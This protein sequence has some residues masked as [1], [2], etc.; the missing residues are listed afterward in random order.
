MSQIVAKTGDYVSQVNSYLV[1]ASYLLNVIDM[2]PSD[3]NSWQN[4]T[5]CESASLQTYFALRAYLNEISSYYSKYRLSTE[6]VLLGRFFDNPPESIGKLTEFIEL[7]RFLSS[8]TR[9]WQ[10]LCNLPIWPDEMEYRKGM[11][12]NALVSQRLDTKNKN[13]AVELIDLK[14]YSEEEQLVDPE[15]LRLMITE[16][17]ELI[18][19]QRSNQMEF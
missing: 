2:L 7:K 17:T 16:L 19:H 10:R 8:S 5:F 9:P 15:S 11:P 6:Q 4:R 18:D 12:S 1:S 3:P 14:E 13:T